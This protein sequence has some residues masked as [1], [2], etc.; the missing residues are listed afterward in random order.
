MDCSVHGTSACCGRSN[1]FEG[2]EKMK[3][4]VVESPAF[5][6]GILR[7]LLGLKKQ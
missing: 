1:S 3:I 7:M 4:L 6:K 5:L 2:G